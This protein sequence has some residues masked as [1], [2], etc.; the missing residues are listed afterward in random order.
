GGAVALQALDES[1]EH[2]ERRAQP[3]LVVVQRRE[4]RVRI[5]R[6]TRRLRRHVGN[7][8]ELQFICNAEDVCRGRAAAVHADNDEAGV[9]RVGAPASG[10][11]V[12][13]RIGKHSR[14]QIMSD[15]ERWPPLPLAAWRDTYATLHMWTQIVGKVCLALTPRTNHWWNVAFQISARG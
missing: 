3:G 2:A 10:G 11:L 1:G 7:I 8:R 6:A 4:K 14:L 5:P 15:S 12:A 9:R 13:M